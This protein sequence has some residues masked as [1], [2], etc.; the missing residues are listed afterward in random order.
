MVMTQVVISHA[1]RTATYDNADASDI[2]STYDTV[3]NSSRVFPS[4]TLAEWEPPSGYCIIKNQKC[5]SF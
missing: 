1:I 4:C 3:E 2:Y 5:I